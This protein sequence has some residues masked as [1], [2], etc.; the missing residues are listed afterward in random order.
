MAN[1]Y[2]SESTQPPSRFY[3]DPYIGPPPFISVIPRSQSG[4]TKS[5]H[6]YLLRAWLELPLTLVIESLCILFD[7]AA[8]DISLIRLQLPWQKRRW[9]REGLCYV[10]GCALG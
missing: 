4:D 9:D 6:Y 3:L 10:F 5:T 8:P 1:G 7:P 2:A